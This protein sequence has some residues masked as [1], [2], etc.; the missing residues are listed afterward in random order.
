[1]AR[2]CLVQGCE[3]KHVMY[4]YCRP[5]GDRWKR[6]GDPG[7]VE[8]G[9]RRERARCSFGECEKPAHGRGL[10]KRHHQRLLIHATAED[11]PLG[12][13]G[14]WAVSPTD[15]AYLAGFVDGEGTIGM[16]RVKLAR[17]RGGYSYEPYVS[18]GN[19]DPTIVTWLGEI[20]GG[21]V[22]TRKQQARGNR[23]LLI[24][25]WEVKSRTAVAV[26]RVLAPFLRM[27]GKQAD[28]LITRCSPEAGAVIRYGTSEA[29][30]AGLM[31][32]HAELKALNRR[33]RSPDE[34]DRDPNG[35][36]GGFADCEG[37]R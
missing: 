25:Q 32:T 4:G 36:T 30:W 5:H 8:I 28:L 6:N 33:G 16:R 29:Y 12:T 15:V 27:K 37:I 24:Y 14:H 1:M 26:C 9:V 13:R 3:R 35:E 21:T 11:P 10:C 20:F 2:L 31:A 7:G 17:N 22:R 19:T 18:V 34:C 23:K